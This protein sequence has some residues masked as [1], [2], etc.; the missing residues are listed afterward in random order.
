MDRYIKEWPSNSIIY[1]FYKRSFHSFNML[2]IK[3]K[4]DDYW[5]KIKKD[6]SR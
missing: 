3:K 6:F 4:L 2:E 1:P 5:E